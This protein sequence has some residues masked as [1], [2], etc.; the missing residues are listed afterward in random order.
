MYIQDT[1]VHTKERHGQ[2]QPAAANRQT[3]PDENNGNKVMDDEK[4]FLG[5]ESAVQQIDHEIRQADLRDPHLSIVYDGRVIPVRPRFIQSKRI[6]WHD[7]DRMRQRHTQRCALERFAGGIR[8]VL[9]LEM[10]VK[11]DIRHA[12]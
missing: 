1:N 5:A 11:K 12:I 3:A 2:T 9:V 7:R 4:Q 8:N 6:Q 10:K